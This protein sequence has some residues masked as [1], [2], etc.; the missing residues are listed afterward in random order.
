VTTTPRYFANR[1][2]AVGSLYRKN[3]S[4]KSSCRC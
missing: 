3:R 1:D 4:L 2:E